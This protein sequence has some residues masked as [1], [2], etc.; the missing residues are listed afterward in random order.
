MT[1]PG[2]LWAFLAFSRQLEGEGSRAVGQKHFQEK[3]YGFLAGILGRINV[4]LT[5]RQSVSGPGAARV[6]ARDQGCARS[7]AGGSEGGQ[8]M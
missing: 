3:E 4:A 2:L 5:L 6:G 1:C 7:L 8:R